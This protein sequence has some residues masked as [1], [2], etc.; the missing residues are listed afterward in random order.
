MNQWEK[1]QHHF[2][3]DGLLRDIYLYSTNVDIWNHFINEISKSKYKCSLFH[4][5]KKIDFPVEFYSIKVLQ[6]NEPTIL[7]VSVNNILVLCHFFID[8]EIELDIAPED[9]NG[10]KDYDDLIEFLTWLSATVQREVVLTYESTEKDIILKVNT[11]GQ[12]TL[13]DP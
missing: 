3:S 7:H 9:I 1:I 10:R 8:D 11:S 13:Y 12:V 5:E 6:E 2:T 4:D